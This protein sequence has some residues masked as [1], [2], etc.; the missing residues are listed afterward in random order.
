M[1]AV[2]CKL[3]CKKLVCYKSY[4]YMYK[5][6]SAINSI[7]W[8]KA[9]KRPLNFKTAKRF[10]DLDAKFKSGAASSSAAADRFHDADGVKHWI[11]RLFRRYE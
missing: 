9:G 10:Y 5:K 6:L 7:I 11:L 8:H 1:V 2:R 4:K 3:Y